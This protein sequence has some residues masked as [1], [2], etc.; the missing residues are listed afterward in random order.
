MEGVSVALLVLVSVLVLM[1]VL[2]LALMQG[3]EKTT[4]S[5]FCQ[6]FVQTRYLTRIFI[7]FVVGIILCIITK[8]DQE[9]L[10]YNKVVTFL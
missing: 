1:L 10:K 7:E 8:F 2:V 4:P 9:I 5:G 6:Y 3:A